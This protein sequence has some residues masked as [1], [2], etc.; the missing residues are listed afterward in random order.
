MISKHY[1]FSILIIVMVIIFVV[2]SPQI[3]ADLQGAKETSD[4][5]LEE[6]TKAQNEEQNAKNEAANAN[7]AAYN[8]EAQDAANRANDAAKRAQ[9]S[10]TRAQ[11]AAEDAQAE[12]NATESSELSLA[13]TYADAA[14][15]SADAAKKAAENAFAAAREAQT[16]ADGKPEDPNGGCLIA[17]ATFGSELSPQVQQLREIRDNVI[18]ETESG[19]NFMSGF[20]E[21]YY[22]FSPTIADLER[23]NPTFKEL[24]KVTITPM[25]STLSIL[26]YVDVDSEAEMLG[27]GIGIIMLNVGMY[28]GLPVL[29]IIGF[30]K[31][32]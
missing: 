19:T 16:I 29:G 22:S 10:A 17:T 31:F 7:N 14:K 18:L 6:M 9:E 32:I 4:K 11:N 5:A 1:R 8:R 23:E 13:Q 25:L 26:N 15:K 28:F 3:F 30:R 2:Q 24:V 20:N 27:Y 21:F 12:V